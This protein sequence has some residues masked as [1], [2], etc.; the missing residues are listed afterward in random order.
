LQLRA[1]EK[2]RHDLGTSLAGKEGHHGAR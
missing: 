1:L 2:L